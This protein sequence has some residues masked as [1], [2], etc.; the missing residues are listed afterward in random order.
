M[1]CL[2]VAH[3]TTHGDAFRS[4][5][6]LVG[7]QQRGAGQRVPSLGEEGR[8]QQTAHL[9]PVGERLCGRRGQPYRHPAG[10][11]GVKEGCC[12]EARDNHFEK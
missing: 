9:V 4:V 11:G 7:H 8:L 12:C 6:P 1:R 10:G 5:V 3:C 2:L